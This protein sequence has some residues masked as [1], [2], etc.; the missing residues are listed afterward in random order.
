MYFYYQ[1]GVNPITTDGAIAILRAVADERCSSLQHLDLSV[2][3]IYYF[4]PQIL[5]K[6]YNPQ[7]SE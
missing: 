1:V 3:I 2:C 5:E 4:S 6:L 7:W